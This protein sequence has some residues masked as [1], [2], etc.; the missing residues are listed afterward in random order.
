MKQMREYKVVI[1][2]AGGINACLDAME[3]GVV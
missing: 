1:V 2:V 3:R